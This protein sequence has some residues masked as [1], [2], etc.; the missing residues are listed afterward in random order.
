MEIDIA[1]TLMTR[2]GVIELHD[3]IWQSFQVNKLSK[4]SHFYFYPRSQ[5]HDVS[6]FY[7]VPNPSLKLNYRLYYA[8]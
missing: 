2:E 1:I 8:D 5:D 3:G 7:K 4:T 6:L